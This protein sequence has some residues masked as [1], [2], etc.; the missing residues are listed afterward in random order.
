MTARQIFT[1]SA[2]SWAIWWATIAL[3]SLLRFSIFRNVS[4]SKRF[5]AWFCFFVYGCSALSFGGGAS[6]CG[7]CLWTSL[8]QSSQKYNSDSCLELCS[9]KISSFSFKAF[10]TYLLWTA[11]PSPDIPQFSWSFLEAHR[12]GNFPCRFMLSEAIC[13]GGSLHWNINKSFIK[14]YKY[15]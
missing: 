13:L 8:I 9:L 12:C 1:L 4:S 11:L 15:I 2:S 10:L 14:N 6:K 7:K 3:S 5:S